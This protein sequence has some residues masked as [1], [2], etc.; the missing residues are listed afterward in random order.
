MRAPTASD[1]RGDQREEINAR[2]RELRAFSNFEEA[3]MP[4]F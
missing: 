1:I 4:P 3:E 2:F